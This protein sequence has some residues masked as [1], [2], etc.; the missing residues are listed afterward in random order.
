MTPAEAHEAMQLV[1]E[2]VYVEVR[3]RD[4]IVVDGRLTRAQLIELARI[5]SLIA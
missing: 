2:E 4:E 5:A 1:N 3:S